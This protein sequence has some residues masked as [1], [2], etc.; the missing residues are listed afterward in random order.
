MLESNMSAP[1]VSIKT[2]AA[3]SRH[4]GGFL[5]VLENKSVKLRGFRGSAPKVFLFCKYSIKLQLLNMLNSLLL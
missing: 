3:L 5:L 4:F 2:R 1:W